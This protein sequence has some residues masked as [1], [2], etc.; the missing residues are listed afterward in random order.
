MPRDRQILVAGTA[1]VPLEYMVPNAVELIPRSINATF[2]GSGAGGDFLPTV[3]IVSD[4]GVVVARVPT[5]A[6]V[7][8]GG[9]AEVTFA[10]FLRSRATSTPGGLVVP[11]AS[12]ELTDP[13]TPLAAGTYFPTIQALHTNAPGASV[14]SVDPTKP[15]YVQIATPGLYGMAGYWATSNPVTLTVG[16]FVQVLLGTTGLSTT[17]NRVIEELANTVATKR[18]QD[19]NGIT[20]EQF[21]IPDQARYAFS[22]GQSIS[23]I[24]PLGWFI[25]QVSPDLVT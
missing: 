9:S 21:A 18:I 11:A 23:N 6:T 19:L 1:P 13:A 12:I 10:P 15:T 4:G 7:A 3:E 17:T 22:T 25:W 8:A 14:F 20:F 24:G 16:S 5:D 2:D